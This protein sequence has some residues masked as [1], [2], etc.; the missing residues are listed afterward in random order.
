MFGVA[1]A[2]IFLFKP[3]AW[4]TAIFAGIFASAS[5][6]FWSVFCFALLG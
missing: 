5:F 2:A 1:S 6:M 4:A 3:R